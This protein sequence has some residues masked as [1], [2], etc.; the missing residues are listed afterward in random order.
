MTGIAA[1][2]NGMAPGAN[3]VAV[4][5][6]SELFDPA[7]ITETNP[8]GY[9]TTL[10]DHDIFSAYDWL[11]EI[12]KDLK[13]EGKPVSILNLSLGGGKFADYCDASDT[14]LGMSFDVFR[15]L[16]EA[17]IL[18]V[19]AAGNE[20]YDDGV[21]LPACFSNVIAVGALTN[22]NDPYIADYSNHGRLVDILAPGSEIRSAYLVEENSLVLITCEDES[23]DGGYLNR[24]L[25]LAE[26]S[27]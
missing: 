11:L 3:I 12:Q 23:V 27:S 6:Q 18:P 14:A 10:R 1:G 15:K 20:K 22:M 4:Q 8:D 25:I 21:N 7:Y 9:S 26:P 17:G 13:A 24:R 2:K 19:A 5:I 16:N